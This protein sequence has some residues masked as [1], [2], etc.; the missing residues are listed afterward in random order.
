MLDTLGVV[1]IAQPSRVLSS[2]QISGMFASRRLGDK[3]LLEWVVRRVTDCQCIDRVV[4]ICTAQVDAQ[5]VS[6]CVPADVE[7]FTCRAPDALG[8]FAAVCRNCDCSSVVRVRVDRPFV[9]PELIDRL[10]SSAHVP[11][12]C[13]Y[14]SYCLSDGRPAVQSQIGVFAEWASAASLLRADRLAV[15]DSER[16]EAMRFIYSRPDLFQLRFIPVPPQLDRD[17]LRLEIDGEEDW[18]LAQV[19]YEALGPEGLEWHRITGLLD[20]QPQIRQR[21]AWLNQTDSD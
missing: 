10:V 6:H 11:P 18:D 5:W 16:S 3:S 12:G 9:D 13:D 17:D 7:I 8:C 1:E 21:M 19:I 4:V 14:A 2:A 20:H 15:G